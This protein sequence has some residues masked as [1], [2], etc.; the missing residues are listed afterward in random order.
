MVRIVSLTISVYKRKALWS[1]ECARR[2]EGGEGDITWEM[3]WKHCISNTALF[4]TSRGP[5]AGA[6]SAGRARARGAYRCAGFAETLKHLE[7][8]YFL[9]AGN[10]VV[11][12][13][14]SS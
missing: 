1:S 13:S 3:P 8:L 14:W 9:G 10:K 4:K 12:D 6:C 2:R 7:G 11:P 5:K